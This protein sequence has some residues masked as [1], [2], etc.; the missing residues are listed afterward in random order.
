MAE[1]PRCPYACVA[2]PEG[3]ILVER[4]LSTGNASD[5]AGRILQRLPRKPDEAGR[6][7]YTMGADGYAFRFAWKAGGPAFVVLERGL[8][9]QVAWR[10]LGS[11][12]KRWEAQMGS[13]TSGLTT[14]AARPFAATLSEL[15][16]DP[17]AAA[18]SGRA[19]E[20]EKP[21]E[22]VQVNERLEQVRGV[23]QDSIEKVL[24]RGERIELLVD[25]ADRLE[26]NATTFAKSSNALR[27]KYRWQNIRCYVF[28]GVAIVGGLGTVAVSSCGGLTL[29]TCV[30]GDGGGAALTDGFT[31][32]A[33]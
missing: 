31:E 26:R 22:L 11:V 27:R 3:E 28:L 29:P 15:L 2:S 12:R 7:S 6:K 21:D 18:G 20:P 9:D 5:L 24:E 33:R 17:V 23:M 30:G 14:M 25:R 8:G 4:S 32:V 19:A 16:E 1:P 13:V 10:F